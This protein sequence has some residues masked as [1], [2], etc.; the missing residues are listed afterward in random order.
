MPSGD[1]LPTSELVDASMLLSSKVARSDMGHM[2]FSKSQ[3][4]TVL[5][6][7]CDC[8]RRV[9][10]SG[11]RTGGEDGWGGVV[12][13]EPSGGVDGAGWGELMA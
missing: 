5:P 1:T 9:P 3:A 4:I 12:W 7:W 2:A 6:G 13:D 8:T 10:G 11:A